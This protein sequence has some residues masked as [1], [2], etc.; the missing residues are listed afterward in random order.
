MLALMIAEGP[1]VATFHTSTTKSLTLS[2][3]QGILRPWHEKIVGRIAVSDLARRWQMEALGSDAVEIPNGVDVDSFASAPVARRLPA[4]R[5]VGAV[6][7]PL[8]R[9]AQ[10]HGRAARRAARPGRGVSRRGGPRRRPRRRGGAARGGRRPGRAPALPRAGR[11]RRRRRRRCAAPTC[12]ARPTPAGRA[13][14]SCWSRRWPRA[15]RWWPATSTRSAGC[16]TTARRAAWCR[17]T[18]PTALAAAL[19]EVLADDAARAALRRGRGRGGAP[20]RLVGGRAGDPAGLRDR[21]RG[22][23][24]GA[25]RRRRRHG[26]RKRRV[27]RAPGAREA[28]E[29]DSDGGDGVITWLVVVALVAAG[30]GAAGRRHLGLPDRAPAGPAARPLR[31]VLAGARRHPGP[32]RR[33]RPRRRHRRLRQRRRGQAAGRAGRRRRTGA[34]HRARGRRERAVGGAGAGRPR[35][36]ARGA[37]RRDGRRRGAG[38]AGAPVPQRRRARHPGAA[39]AAAGALAA[40][41]RNRRRCQPISRSPSGPRSAPSGSR[42]YKRT[43]ARVVLLDEL[44][45]RAAVLRLRPGDATARA[46]LVVHRRRRRRAGRDAARR[47]GPGTRRGDRVC[48]SARPT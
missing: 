41:R 1:I 2:V 48:A 19:I 37:G 23:R 18:T 39:R 14:A 6:P 36:A 45:L 9:T 11:R 26:A 24:E 38:A 33:R 27:R 13:S 25:G 12:T 46:A 32:P 29:R 20:L 34:A 47:G 22:G 4:A 17:S 8:R 16:S 21:R 40:P 31:P 35:V 15:R 30:G 5:P 7:R 44:R 3:F 42:S 28:A 43:S 10:G